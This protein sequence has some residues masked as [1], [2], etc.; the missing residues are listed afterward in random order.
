VPDTAH[1]VADCSRAGIGGDS[2][3]A[4]AER[5]FHDVCRATEACVNMCADGQ[6][7]TLAC[8][9]GATAFLS[10]SPTVTCPCHAVASLTVATTTGCAA[11][12]CINTEPACVTTEPPCATTEP[13]CGTTE[14]ASDIAKGLL[15][16]RGGPGR[17]CGLVEAG[18]LLGML[19][20]SGM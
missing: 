15:A 9:G 13:P 19:E 3:P 2:C 16:C 7:S 18:S 10:I 4:A 17:N 14:P 12:A 20:A 11:P 6:C 8:L 5:G 1:V